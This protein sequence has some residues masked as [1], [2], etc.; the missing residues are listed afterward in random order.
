[1]EP[2]FHCISKTPMTRRI[3]AFD[4]TGGLV[5]IPKNRTINQSREYNRILNY[6]LI[7]IDK[8]TLNQKDSNSNL[9]A[10][11]MVL[12]FFSSIWRKKT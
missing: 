10:L 1:M 6:Y 5:K 8:S 9:I 12:P 2:Q 11:K 3:C 4:A 7:L